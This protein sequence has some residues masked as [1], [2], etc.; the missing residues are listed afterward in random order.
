MSAPKKLQPASNPASYPTLSETKLERRTFL[1]G[2]GAVAAAAVGCRGLSPDSVSGDVSQ[3]P[4]ADAS[5][6]G[7]TDAGSH[8]ADPSGPDDL[9]GGAPAERPPGAGKKPPQAP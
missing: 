1:V 2:A 5:T 7:M 4:P 9:S 6:E 8:A 3:P